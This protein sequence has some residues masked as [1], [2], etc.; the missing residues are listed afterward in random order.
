MRRGAKKT[1]HFGEDERSCTPCTASIGLHQN[2]AVFFD[3]S[4]HFFVY[5]RS[6]IATAPSSFILPLASRCLNIL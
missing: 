5:L 4:S 6:K 1:R 3:A 2:N